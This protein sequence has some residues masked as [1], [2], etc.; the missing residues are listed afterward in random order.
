MFLQVTLPAKFRTER[1]SASWTYLLLTPSLV[2]YV[3]TNVVLLM[4]A[5]PGSLTTGIP[6]SLYDVRTIP[7]V[8]TATYNLVVAPKAKQKCYYTTWIIIIDVHLRMAANTTEFRV[9]FVFT[10]NL[11]QPSTRRS[12]CVV[13]PIL[14]LTELVV[15][16]YQ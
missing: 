7:S 2:S 5:R 14:N 9:G 15:L 10:L 12:C 8:T 3:T 13:P 6:G 1:H 4:N 11:T 16:S